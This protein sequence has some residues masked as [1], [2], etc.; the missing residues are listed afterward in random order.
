MGM[1]G[2]V[3]D[4]GR[5][6]EEG[7]TSFRVISRHGNLTLELGGHLLGSFQWECQRGMQ[8]HD[9]KRLQGRDLRGRVDI[10]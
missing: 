10:F 4:T 7:T 8:A 6:C 9:W 5:T 2:C 3:E 1:N